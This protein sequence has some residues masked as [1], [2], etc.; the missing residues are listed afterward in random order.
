MDINSIIINAIEAEKEI[1]IN[2]YDELI[3]SIEN[4]TN[5]GKLYYTLSKA[6]KN[7]MPQ[8]EIQIEFLKEHF[9]N[10]FFKNANIKNNVNYI[11]FEDSEFR[12]R[13]SKSFDRSI[14][15]LY[16]KEISQPYLYKYMTD[17]NL[18]I[19]E[20][21]KDYMNKKSF[22]KLEAIMAIRHTKP[23]NFIN[24]LYSYKNAYKRY[25]NEL[26]KEFENQITGDKKKAEEYEIKLD[27]Y[28]NTKKYIENFIESLTDLKSF[29]E[30]GFRIKTN[31]VENSVH[32]QY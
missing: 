31:I 19:Y 32:L 9:E 4:E 2:E 25:N 15:V 27:E 11:Y 24:K 6:Y 17:N 21:L 5:I 30:I 3:K 13:L 26:L 22:K 16:K 29:R 18:K 28:N 14:E 20:L 1:K 8:G 23:N 12:I 7:T 10:D